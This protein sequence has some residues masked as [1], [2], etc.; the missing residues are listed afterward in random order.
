MF[1]FVS[2]AIFILFTN[3]V[4]YAHSETGAAMLCRGLHKI[5]YL[6]PLLP[7]PLRTT[8]RQDLKMETGLLGYVQRV[9]PAFISRISFWH[10]SMRRWS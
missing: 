1:S 2:T 9:S 7:T 6:M 8:I 3:H 4:I 5:G 10:F